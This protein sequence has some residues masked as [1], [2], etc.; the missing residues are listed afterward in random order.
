MTRA[1]LIEQLCRW[2]DTL[3]EPAGSLEQLSVRAH[4]VADE[5]ATRA[6]QLADADVRDED[7]PPA[8]AAG[9]VR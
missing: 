7:I 2:A 8:I 9:F 1:W 6:G 5:M 4:V 3:R